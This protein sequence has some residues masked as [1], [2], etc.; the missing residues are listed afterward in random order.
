MEFK[1]ISRELNEIAKDYDYQ[2][3]PDILLKLQELIASVLRFLK[4]LFNYF[5]VPQFESSDSTA[6]AT[7]LQV[8]VVLVGLVAA[9]MVVLLVASRLRQ[10]QLQKQAA[11]GTMIAEDGPLDSSGWSALADQLNDKGSYKEACRAVYMSIL[12]LLDEEKVMAFAATKTNY[13]YFYALK[14]MPNIA[15]SFRQL[16]DRVEELWFGDRRATA[17]DFKDCREQAR[18]IVNALPAARPKILT[19]AAAALHADEP[20]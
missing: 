17:Q 1:N 2:Q 5:K 12:L 16:V 18:A 20:K 4:D 9:V 13:E 15:T 19:A 8:I 3:P 14:R 11:L 10:L 6:V 7:I